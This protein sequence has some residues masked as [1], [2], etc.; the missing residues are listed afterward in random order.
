MRGSN[1]NR[2]TKPGDTVDGSL[3]YGE[4]GSLAIAE[5]VEE[6]DQQTVKKAG[7]AGIVEH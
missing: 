4:E 3:T 6:T 5:W 2:W 1:V 7:P